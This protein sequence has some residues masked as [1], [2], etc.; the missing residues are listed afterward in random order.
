MQNRNSLLVILL[1]FVSTTVFSQTTYVPLW[2]KE[3]W[4]LNRLEI[5]A[6]TNND[7]NLS[8]VKPYMRKAYVAVADSFRSM[9]INGENPARLSKVDQYNLNRFQAN[10]KEYSKYDVNSMPEWNRKKPWTKNL[11][12]TTGSFLEVNEKDFYLL[13]NP[14]FNFNAGKESNFD[15]MLY[16]NSKGATFRGLIAKKIGFDFFAADNQE[17]GPRQFRDFVNTNK[18][19]PGEAFFKSFKGNGVDYFDARGSINANV[20]RYINVQ[21]GYD[22]NFIGNGYRSLFLSDFSAPNLFLKLNTRIWK[23]NYTNLFMELFPTKKSANNNNEVLARKYS[24]MHHLSINATKWLNVGVFEGVVFGRKDKFDFSYLLPVIFLR[25]IEGNNGS[26][27][28][29]NIGIDVKANIKRKVQLYGQVLIDEMNISE[30]RKDKTYWANKIGLQLG[31][32]YVDVFNISNLDLQVEW[33]RVRPFTYSHF[34]S[35]GSYT[36]YNQPLAHP[37][38]ANFQEFIGILNYQPIPK[39]YLTAKAIFYKKGLDSAGFTFGS[40]PNRTYEAAS[41]NNP[42]GRIR[43]NNYPMFSGVPAKCLYSSFTGS[44]ELFEN[45]F[46]DVTGSLRIFKA[47]NAAEINTNTVSFGIRWNMFRREYDY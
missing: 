29:A 1:A 5:K 33:N 10:N 28:N 31:G 18:A 3:G 16:V 25:S 36:H 32:K 4:L 39:L 41:I 21:F 26:P 24:A 2:A 44:Y 19:V 27:D 42:F 47:E 8:T 37:L 34:D 38:G 40:N 14:V 20:T 17:R 22:K 9:L 46:I 30:L 45:M 7:L 13:V 12:P 15:D 23:L 43:Y 35:V 11:F 6:Q